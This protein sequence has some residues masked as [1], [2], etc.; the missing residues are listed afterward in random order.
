[1]AT[2]NKKVTRPQAEKKVKESAGDSIDSLIESLQSRFGEGAIMK[3]GEHHHSKVETIPSGSFS[4]DI[5]LG[6][7]FPK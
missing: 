3:L 2:N 6:N 7:G 5:A 4:L 1:M